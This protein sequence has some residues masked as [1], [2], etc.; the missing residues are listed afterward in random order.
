MCLQG[1]V[2]NL[3]LIRTVIA[4][5]LVSLPCVPPSTP[6]SKDKAGLQAERVQAREKRRIRE[7][8]RHKSKNIWRHAP[9]RTEFEPDLIVDRFKVGV[10]GL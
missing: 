7:H 2:V 8:A 6:E 4:E 3:D 9:N 5:A 1:P 10:D